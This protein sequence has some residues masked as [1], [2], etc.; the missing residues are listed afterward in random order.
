MTGIRVDPKHGTDP[1]L[2][3]CFW[4]GEPKDVLLFGKMRSETKKAFKLRELCP[5]APH[6]VIVD[7][8]P[9][10]A[11][12]EIMSRGICFMETDGE[13]KDSRLTGHYWVL[14]E[15]VVKEFVTPPELLAAMLEK[16]KTYVGRETAK[17]IGL[18]D[19]PVREES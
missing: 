17:R 4:C 10:A 9:C 15:S 13:G 3:C 5:R 8:E 19:A 6:K 2:R 16:R 14:A 1:A 18:Y 12:V 11:C 7:H